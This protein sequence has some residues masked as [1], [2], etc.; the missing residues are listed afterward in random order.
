MKEFM[1]ICI[2]QA[3]QRR[4]IDGKQES[5]WGG[6]TL[7]AVIALSLLITIGLNVYFIWY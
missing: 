5:F 1:F 4:L 6:V 2:S 7:V 3:D